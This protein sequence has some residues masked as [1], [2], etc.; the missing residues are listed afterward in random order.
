MTQT[1]QAYSVG[2]EGRQ[3]TLLDTPGF[4]DTKRTDTEIL[5]E[6][7]IF[8]DETYKTKQLLSGIIYLT[9]IIATR[10]TGSSV[11]NLKIF[12]ELVGPNA[13]QNICL[14][15]TMWDR[16]A[17]RSEGEAREE[18]LCQNFWGHF[19]HKG[20]SIARSFGDRNSALSIVRRVTFGQGDDTTL[21]APLQLQ[22]EMVDQGKS[23]EETSAGQIL[24]QEL[25]AMETRH[26]EEMQYLQTELREEIEQ[27]RK[28]QRKQLEREIASERA[29]LEAKIEQLEKDKIQLKTERATISPK[30]PAA[31]VLIHWSIEDSTNI[32]DPPPPYEV[33]PISPAN[34]FLKALLEVGSFSIMPMYEVQRLVLPPLTRVLR[35]RLQKGY[36]RIEWTCVSV[37]TQQS[38]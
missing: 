26:R 14:V 16:L 32:Y 13:F 28:D 23:L 10:M 38:P 19:I 7:A 36:S 8:L 17:N 31:N 4:N 20:A 24:A 33:R 12:E 15:T 27:L 21:I 25:Q 11:R 5:S 30:G 6:I 9:P 29:R 35:P 37:I 3:I 22:Q 1:V 18:D 2:L 34:K